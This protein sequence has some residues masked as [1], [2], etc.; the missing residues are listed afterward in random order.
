MDYLT[1]NHKM[2]PASVNSSAFVVASRPIPKSFAA[3][4]QA[5]QNNSLLPASNPQIAM[6]LKAQERVS[7]NA[8][9]EFEVK[10]YKME[11]RD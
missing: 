3:I 1:A 2:T 8:K 6:S 4:K 10:Q 11:K 9:A 5:Q 7:L